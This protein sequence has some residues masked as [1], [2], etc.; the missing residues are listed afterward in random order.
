L[1]VLFFIMLFVKFPLGR[2]GR[3]SDSC[4]KEERRL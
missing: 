4:R 3:K 1:C 2:G